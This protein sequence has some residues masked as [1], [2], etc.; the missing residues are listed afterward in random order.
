MLKREIPEKAKRYELSTNGAFGMVNLEWPVGDS[1][2]AEI[3]ALDGTNAILVDD[4]EVN[5]Y[6]PSFDYFYMKT[7]KNKDGFTLGN[8]VTKICKTGYYALKSWYKDFPET[9]DVEDA[10]EAGQTVGEYALISF[11]RQGNNIYVNV[12]H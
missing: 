2:N 6:F 5:I 9:F 8:I 10:E 3:A 4:V 12:E 11:N 1:T 7:Y